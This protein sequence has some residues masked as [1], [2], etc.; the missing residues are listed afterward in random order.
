[1][2]RTFDEQRDNTRGTETGVLI[3]RAIEA[4]TEARD[5]IARRQAAPNPPPGAP[6]PGSKE[7]LQEE[8]NKEKLDPGG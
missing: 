1:V 6:E 2:L 5:A 4:I 8:L 3:T 7:E